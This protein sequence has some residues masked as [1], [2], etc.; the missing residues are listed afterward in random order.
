MS[1]TWFDIQLNDIN[2]GNNETVTESQVSNNN[3]IQL[4]RD[5]LNNFQQLDNSLPLNNDIN[6]NGCS[7]LLEERKFSSPPLSP[8]Y[9]I[10]E[11]QFDSDVEINVSNR[12]R[13]SSLVDELL[14]EI[15]CN[16]RSYRNRGYSISSDT[17][18]YSTPD[19]QKKPLIRDVY[20]KAKGKCNY[21]RIKRKDLTNPFVPVFSDKTVSGIVKESKVVNHLF[22]VEFIDS[23]RNR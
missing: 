18:N 17:S 22:F 6:G 14:N 21:C 2:N 10:S 9:S 5:S 13:I 4:K 8:N 12:G 19:F 11:N 7:L 20:L 3:N 1:N 23:R 15:Y 16:L